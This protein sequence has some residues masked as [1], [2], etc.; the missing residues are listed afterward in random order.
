MATI[1]ALKFKTPGGAEEAL[2]T[3]QGLARDHLIELHDAAIVTWKT[4]K[5]RPKTQQLNNLAGAG[6]V[7]GAFWGMLFGMIFFMPFVGAAFGA[8]SGALAGSLTDIGINDEFIR[9]IKEQVTEGTS[10]LFLMIGDA[11]EDKGVEAMKQYKFE[12]IS[13]NLSLEH[14]NALRKAFAESA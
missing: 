14:E 9:K 12:I 8:T 5:K 4:G 2:Q 10:C 11:T 1:S 13:T 3:I 6:A 7:D